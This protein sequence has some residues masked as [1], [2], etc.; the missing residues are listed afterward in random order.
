[1][2]TDQSRTPPSTGLPGLDRILNGLIL[3]DNVVLQVESMD[4]YQPFVDAYVR[5]A[6]AERRKLVY[7]RF[8]RHRELIPES[9]DVRRVT[10]SPD[11]GFE[12]FVSDV[13]DVIGAC[14]LEAFYLFDCLSELAVDWFSDRTLANFFMIVCPYLYRLDTIAYFA[15]MK[16][17]HSATAVDGIHGTAQV[18]IDVFRHNGRLYVQPCKADGR[19]SRTMFTLHEWHGDTF[20][21][22]NSSSTVS[23]VLAHMPQPW[24]EFSLSRPG[25]W[26]AHFL[27]AQQVLQKQLEDAADPRESEACF[28][29]LMRMALTREKRFHG[30]VRQYLTLEDLIRVLGRMVGTGLIGGK[31]LGML[32]ARAMLRKDCPAAG[33]VLEPHDSFFVGSDVFYTHLVRNDCWWLRRGHSL[34]ERLDKAGTARERV[35]NGDFPESVTQQFEEMLDYF[36]QSPLIVRS[37]SLLEDNYGNAF[38]GKY[39]SVFCANQG[40]PEDRLEAFLNAVRHVYASSLSPDALMYRARSGLLEQDEQ[41]A[42]LIQRVSGTRFGTYVAP[43]AAGVG[44]SFNAYAW[45]EDIDPHAGMLRLVV[46]LGTRAV[47]RTDD[48]YATLVAL[49]A[50]E[51]R[52]HTVQEDARRYSQHKVDVIDLKAN[53]LTSV[54]FE[55]LIAKA[56][57]FPVDSVAEPDRAAMNRARRAGMRQAAAPWLPNLAPMLR[58]EGLVNIM[59]ASLQTLEK[60]YGTPVDVEFTLNLQEDDRFSVNLVQCRPFQIKV[61][62]PADLTTL[63]D[64]P[65]SARTL[66]RSG[67]PIIGPSVLMELD[68]TIYVVPSTYSRLPMSDRYAVARLIGQLTRLGDLPPEAGV[69]LIGPGRWGTSTP[70]LGI[71][72]TFGEIEHVSAIVEVAVM[73]EGLVP[74]VSLGTHFFNDLVELDMLYMAVLPN[75]EA[76]TLDQVFFEEETENLLT[77]LLP[78]AVEFAS[79]VRVIGKVGDRAIHLYADTR[80]Q[81]AFCYADRIDPSRSSSSE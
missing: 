1:M 10:V 15:L 78:D 59:Q 63:S 35:M 3:G 48:D 33:A 54:P 55:D 30:L 4:D 25:I 22:V 28:D 79:V 6:V 46:G 76:H 74:D 21:P 71:P 12:A 61:K 69:L 26:R 11:M 73:H 32:L 57:G 56:D 60:A 67:G 16:K 39:E 52:P 68:R 72:T 40:R 8:A 44:F 49:N 47:D 37:S 29:R 24:L 36:G 41:M 43:H 77:T 70:A 75:R 19:Y 65:A 27:H 42:L 2:S 66:L 17:H 38:S 18:I 5:Q 23:E 80:H 50:P 45:H 9:P 58:R 14:G 62:K 20:E 34:E 64:V 31:A 81:R 13:V 53:S 51:A 7:F